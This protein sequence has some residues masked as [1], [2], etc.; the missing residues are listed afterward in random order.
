MRVLS[1]LQP[2]AACV[3]VA[4]RHV[5]SLPYSTSHRGLLC[6]YAS[7]QIEES[8]KFTE[9]E[10]L[11]EGSAWCTDAIIG[12]VDLIGTTRNSES[13]WA[14]PGRVHWQFANAC[15]FDTPIVCAHT[16]GLWDADR[17]LVRRLAQEL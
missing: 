3:F 2:H 4:G 8:R 17:D 10:T 9:C 15:L 5:H 14:V 6:I 7:R 13:P 1:I 16:I 11:G 12:C